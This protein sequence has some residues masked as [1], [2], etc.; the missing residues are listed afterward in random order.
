MSRF[1]FA[2][3][4]LALAT[5]L[6]SQPAATNQ[7]L[8]LDGNNSCVALPD[9][10][11][12]GLN[13]ATVELWAR[14]DRAVRDAHFLHLG[15]AGN[16]LYLAPEGESALKLLY[17]DRAA[18]RHRIVLPDLLDANVWFHVAAVFTDAGARLYLNGALVGTLP[19]PASPKAI[20]PSN[21]FLGGSV[22][23]GGRRSY[24][25][26]RLDD[27]RLWGVARTAEQI[28]GDMFRSLSGSE[29]GLVSLWG[30]DDGT[31]R[32]AGRLQRHGRLQGSAR[33][34]AARRPA[35][36]A[37]LVRPARLTGIVLDT[38]GLPGR[39]AHVFVEQDARVVASTRT[40]REGRFRIKS[41]ETNPVVRL[42]AL[43]AGNMARSDRFNPMAAAGR[44]LDLQL[45]A[46]GT[47]AV[48]VVA[49]LLESLRHG[50][51][52]LR[53]DVMEAL[54]A[55]DAPSAREAAVL[56]QALD[57]PERAVRVTAEQLLQHWPAPAALGHIYEKKGQAMAWLLSVPLVPIA[58]FH[59]LLFL[60]Y[61]KGTSNL[62][63]A[64]YAL[65]AAALNYYS[66]SVG[67]SDPTG[68]PP[69]LVLS[70]VT[71]LLGLRLLYSLFY[72]RMPRLFW[73]F[74]GPGAL[75]LVGVW[76]SWNRFHLLTGDF[77]EAARVGRPFFFLLLT[78]VGAAV[79]PALAGLEMCRV[80]VL[81][82]FK[83][84]RGAWIIG[85]GFI[86]FLMFQV[87]GSLGRVFAQEF[88]QSLFGATLADYVSDLGA[89]IFI[90][91]ASV[92]LASDFAQTNRSLRKAKE[93]IETK[94][95]ELRAAKE[96]ADAANKAK[97]RFLANMSHEL[98]TPLNAIIGYSEMLAEEA[99]D[100]GQQ[101]FVP[102]LKKI[103]GAGKHLLSLI[104]D[105]LDLSKIEAGKMT[106]FI[107]EFDVPK[108]VQE[109]AATV[110]PLMARNANRF[111]VECPAD[112][113]RMKADQT[114]VRQTLF[115]L[116]SNA[117]KFTDKGTIRLAVQR[118]PATSSPS[119]LNGERA[120]VRGENVADAPSSRT[121][122]PP[123]P[124]PLPPLRGG[125][126]ATLSAPRDA[127]P[128][129]LAFTVT[130]TG[131]GMTPEQVARLFQAFEQADH[132][133]SK[134]YG[135]TGL[136]LV[137]SRTFCRMMGGD[138]TVESAPGRGTTFTARLPAET[139]PPA[140]PLLP[141]EGHVQL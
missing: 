30:F 131:I 104:S 137:L 31:A 100:L 89:L 80:V 70:V 37:E 79:V 55:L 9:G 130:D 125:E 117:A 18:I 136:G 135:G 92:Y 75:A 6:H 96:A 114:K 124:S 81:A 138:L 109:V 112:L 59:L 52:E 83:R 13:E 78:M 69:L 106:L 21:N 54:Q 98:R 116:L 133:T 57:D 39:G 95:A 20:D 19:A 61:P 101:D 29:E 12:S 67:T 5:T 126:G 48:E 24:F 17:T 63:F 120:G 113:G 11:L 64:A 38:K 58:L 134:K 99:V 76:M 42:L 103:H 51:M 44:S 111:E 115:N 121:A 1:G 87:L 4:L 118:T 94:N 91:C 140:P 122:A 35:S 45:A 32:D 16:E 107:E 3:L 60:F 108:L 90:G 74:V 72:E 43:R 68:L 26:G 49:A 53:N 119:P 34:V 33:V 86:S 15:R 46:P 2:L 47:N 97:S 110:Q 41:N 132:S 62:Y 14:M 77:G 129:I 128:S 7:V 105:V 23:Q 73:L 139:P 40:D 56:I 93:E 85:V 66:A 22:L 123:H 84:K 71:T 25:H 8:H 141:A 10:V 88:L 102:D 36:A 127:R 28:Q 27:V 82:M 65:A 50:P